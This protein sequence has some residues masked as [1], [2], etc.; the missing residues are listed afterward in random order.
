MKLKLNYN[1]KKP[2][3]KLT[4]TSKINLGLFFSDL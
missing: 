4:L 3:F 1:Q 2:R